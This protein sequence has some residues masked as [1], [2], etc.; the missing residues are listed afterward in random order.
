MKSSP[1]QRP[2]YKMATGICGFDELCG[3]LPRN[4][5]TLIM[6]GPGTGKTIFALHALVSA[7]RDRKQSGIFVGFE[8]SRRDIIANCRLV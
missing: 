6:G 3:G 2:L 8:E 4:R 5:T 1:S 7:A